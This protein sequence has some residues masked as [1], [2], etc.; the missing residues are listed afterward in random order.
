[1][2]SPVAADLAWLEREVGAV[3][4]HPLAA[5]TSFGI[6]GAADWFVE[7]DSPGRLREVV[8]GCRQRGLP[9]RVIGAGTN[10][11]VADAGVEGLVIRCTARSCTVE[12]DRIQAAAGL[13]LIRLA[14]VAAGAGLRGLEFAIGVPGSVGGALYQNA[15]CWGGEVAQVL[16]S[17]ELIDPDGEVRRVPA[18]ELELGYRTSALKAGRFQGWVVLSAR[19]RLTPGDGAAARAQMADWTA[20]RRATQPVSTRN[21]GSVF[22]NP[23]G[24]SAGRLIESCGL[25]G[26]RVGG[27]EVSRLHANFIIN[28]EGATAADVAMLIELIQRRVR[29]EFGIHLEPEVERIGR[30]SAAPGAAPWAE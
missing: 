11:L 12:G 8:A 20:R 6:G 19:F 30:W 29:A 27:A 3:P 21:C 2:S 28:R 5:H 14:R 4:D 22:R 1:M 13:K 15:G 17:C 26:L 18:A 10:L 24:D 16:E 9:V 23:E 25:K 7:I